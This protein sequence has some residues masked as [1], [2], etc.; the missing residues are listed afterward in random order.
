[1]NIQ[2]GVTY[3]SGKS[4]R[5][6]IKRRSG[7]ERHLFW[8]RVHKKSWPK[9]KNKVEKLKDRAFI[10][11]RPPEAEYEYGHWEGDFIVSKQNS[12][13]LLELV[14]KQSKQTLV[15]RIPNRKNVLVNNRIVE[16][17]KRYSV[18]SLTL[19]NDIAFQKH[20]KLAEMLN[21]NIYFCHP[22]HSWEKGL[23]ENMN[24]W[25]RVFV[26]KKTNIGSITNE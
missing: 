20:K 25:I 21:T 24:R 17:L 7:L 5:K 10:D 6:Y 26:P 2:S 16:M 1:M 4:I 3:A 8:N 14:E 12:W 11:Q 15:E 19:D 23:V 22:Y 9:K 18:K 13:A